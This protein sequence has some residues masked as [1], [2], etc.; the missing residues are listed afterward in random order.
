[1]LIDKLIY[2]FVFS[3]FMDQLQELEMGFIEEY[4]SALLL[5]KYSKKK[6]AI[7]LFSKALFALVD[8]ILFSRYKKLPK[9]HT[10][11]FRILQQKEE[12]IYT[13][14][15]S[16]WSKYTDTYSKPS[17]EESID[18]LQSVIIEVISY[19]GILSQKIKESAGKK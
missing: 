17:V 19:D 13:L 15:D 5:L 11:R 12:R 1:M 4:E 2:F 16:V 9:N 7:I 14:V 10:E 8:Y 3:S 6:S 18:L